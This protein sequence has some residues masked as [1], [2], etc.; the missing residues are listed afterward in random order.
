MA[1][2]KLAHELGDGERI[3]SS[4]NNIALVESA[5]GDHDAALAHVEQSAAVAESI[6][7]RFLKA[8]ILD[9]G[10]RIH[11]RRGELDVA[12]M[13]WSDALRISVELEDSLNVADSLEGMALMAISKGDAIRAI[14]LVAAADAIR[15]ATVSER[16]PEWAAE[17]DAGLMRAL[18]KLNQA[19]AESARLQ[20]ARMSMPEAVSLYGTRRPEAVFAHTSPVY[21]SCG[22]H[23]WSRRDPNQ[24][25]RMLTLIEAGLEHIRNK[26]GLRTRAQIAVWAHERVGTA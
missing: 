7:N 15:T 19:G 11:F 16:T 10:G 20:G 4:L 18:T 26:L 8:T 14:V 24:D 23:E 21:V 25:Q 1:A 2:G 17:V 3:A 13:T 22:D 5:L 9:T 6:G 12:L